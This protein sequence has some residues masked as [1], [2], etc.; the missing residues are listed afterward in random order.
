MRRRKKIRQINLRIT[1]DLRGRL[2]RAA[3][4][5]RVSINQLMRQLL[6]AGLENNAQLSLENVA[7]RLTN[8]ENHLQRFETPLGSPATLTGIVSPQQQKKERSNT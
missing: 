7:R 5:R 8:L 6:E 4:E 3:D 1:D 2:Q